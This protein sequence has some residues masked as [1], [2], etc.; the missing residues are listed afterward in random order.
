M[1]RLTQCRVTVIFQWYA[2]DV[3]RALFCSEETLEGNKN[4]ILILS[5][6]RLQYETGGSC[7]PVGWTNP[8]ATVGMAMAGCS[9][10]PGMYIICCCGSDIIACRKHTQVKHSTTS[11]SQRE[12]RLS[13]L[14][15]VRLVGHSPAQ[16]TSVA[17]L[18][19][20]T[21]GLQL[22][23]KES[24]QPH[25]LLHATTSTVRMC[26][27]CSVAHPSLAAVQTND[28]TLGSQP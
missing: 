23:S 11:P 12:D 25:V 27:L 28:Q 15:P 2:V 13:I 16:G 7:L 24:S 5:T 26:A 20:V 22:V 21:V 6:K 3:C 10:T 14:V 18:S 19:A 4:Q 8:P 9:G 17:G 1:K